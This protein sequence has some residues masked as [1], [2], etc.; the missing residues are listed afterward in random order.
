M[1]ELCSNFLAYGLP[2]SVSTMNYNSVILVGILFITTAW[3]IIH[4]FK[5]YPGPKLIGLYLE[6]VDAKPE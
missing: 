6:G 5:N 2:T 3:W 4:G 1:A